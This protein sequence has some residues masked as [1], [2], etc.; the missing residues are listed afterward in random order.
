MISFHGE[1][2]WWRVVGTSQGLRRAIGGDPEAAERLRGTLKHVLA[3][4]SGQVIASACPHD[5]QG[6]HRDVVAGSHVCPIC[7]GRPRV[8]RTA[9]CRK[10]IGLASAAE[11][12][13]FA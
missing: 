6:A 2:E 13:P 4:L 7:V 3:K 10:T 1:V 11:T 8:C 12:R 5:L 9:G